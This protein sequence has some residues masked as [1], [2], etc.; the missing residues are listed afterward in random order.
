MEQ[1][2]AAFDLKICQWNVIIINSFNVEM[3]AVLGFPLP[4]NYST[5]LILY[6]Q[7]FCHNKISLYCDHILNLGAKEREL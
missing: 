3:R 2:S 4:T 7:W 5:F 6:S 1:G